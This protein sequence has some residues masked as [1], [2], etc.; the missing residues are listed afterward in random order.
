[1]KTLA[2][3]L[4]LAASGCAGTT[5][6]TFLEYGSRFTDAAHA[7]YHN[8][9]DGHEEK[10]ECEALREHYNRAAGGLLKL[11]EKVPE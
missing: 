6:Q 3:A 9:C 5:P 8:A 11:N 10:P 7:F 2:L 4:S 1:M